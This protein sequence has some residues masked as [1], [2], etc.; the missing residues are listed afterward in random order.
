ML[1][2]LIEDAAAIEDI[3]A[4][5]AAPGINGLFVGPYDLS[6]SV[7]APGA[8]FD[9]PAMSSALDRVVASCRR[10]GKLVLT[11]IGDRQERDYSRRL[12][13]RGVQG[14]VLA[15]DALVLLQACRRLVEFAR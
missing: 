8:D 13:A 4:I 2:P 6:V 12:V 7:G 15:T 9:H 5:A 11:T 3:A 14:L 1:L 10:H